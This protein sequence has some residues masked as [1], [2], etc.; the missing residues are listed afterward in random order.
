MSER[1]R[2]WLAK[3]S[4][5]EWVLW[6]LVFVVAVVLV[7]VGHGGVQHL[8]ISLIVLCVIETLW[9]GFRTVRTQ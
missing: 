3:P 7:V 2:R 8:G 4:P 5:V 6:G 1:R 9:M